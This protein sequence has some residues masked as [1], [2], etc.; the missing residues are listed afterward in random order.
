MSPTAERRIICQFSGNSDGPILVCIGGLHGNEPSGVTALIQ[1]EEELRRRNPRFQGQFL[2]VAGNLTALSSGLRF[3]H[4][5]LNRIWTA[6]RV[7]GLLRSQPTTGDLN[8]EGREQLELLELINGIFHRR[9]EQQE[10]FFV[11]L[12][13]TSAL[14]GPFTIFGDTLAN[15]SFARHFPVPMILGLEEQIEGVLLDYIGNRGAVTLGFEAGPHQSPESVGR[16]EAAGRS[17]SESQAFCAASGL[18]HS[19]IFSPEYKTI[20]LEGAPYWWTPP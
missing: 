3:V 9:E 5:D 16:H 1:V 15:R 10:V 7:E 20:Q 11:D 2:G 18:N 19:C 8:L 13:T 4:E 17:G 14:G 6:E 12:H